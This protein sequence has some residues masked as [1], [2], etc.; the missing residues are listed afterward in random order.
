MYQTGQTPTTNNSNAYTAIDRYSGIKFFAPRYIARRLVLLSLL[1]NAGLASAADTQAPSVPRELKA[2]AASSSQLDLRW[3]ASSDNQGVTGYTVYLNDRSYKRAGGT[4]TSITGLQP[5]TTYKVRVSA[6]DAAMNHSAWTATPVSVKTS[7]TTTAPPPPAGTT[8]FRCSFSSSPRECGFGEQSKV[9]G[10]ATLTSV[11]R[12]GGTAALLRTQPG[13]NN[14][15][16]S[17]VYERD[18][19][20]LSQSATGCSQGQTQWWA[21]S[22]RFPNEY[23]VPPSGSVWHWGIVFDFH[24]TGPTGQ[25]NLQIVSTPTGLVFWVA[26]GATVV[27]GPSSPGHFAAPIGPVV[28][29]TW[30][31]FVYNVHWSSGSDGYIKGWLNGVLKLNYKGPTLYTGQ[32]C[33]LKLA[34]YHTAMGVPVSIIHDRIVRGTS[35][36]AVA[37]QPLQ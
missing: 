4:M 22:M 2:V 8:T 32:G 28:K 30:Y 17:G 1:A 27:T 7:S 3:Y 12:D 37:L 34:N 14:V 18:D 9:A 31:D 15:F 11:A 23:V 6:Y 10:R 16:G 25:A 26:G 13:D 33:Y 21:H 20:T 24:H 36:A 29:N 5:G 19:L 35:A